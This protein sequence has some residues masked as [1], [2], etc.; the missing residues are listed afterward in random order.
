[1]TLNSGTSFTG[2]GNVGLSGGQL[3]VGS[4]ISMDIGLT[5]SM[6]SGTMSGTGNLI[7][8]G[9]FNW[10]GG[11]LTSAGSTTCNGALTVSGTAALSLGQRILNVNAATTYTGTG[12]LTLSNGA[13]INNNGTWD[14]QSDVTIA[15]GSGAGS[16]FKNFGTFRKSAGAGTTTVQPP[17]TNS[18]TVDVQSGT[19]S[20]ASYSQTAGTTK[21]TGGAFTSAAN[22]A[23]SGGSLAGSGSV[24][25][26][27][28]VSGT[29]ALAPG[30][31][32]GTLS[33]GGAYTQQAPSGAFNVEL[34]GLTPGTQYDRV[35]VMGAAALAGVLN[36]SLI[37]G[38]APA[39]G[40][41]F[42]IMTY[43]SRTGTF[44]VSLPAAPCVDWQVTYGATA[45]VLTA[46][47]A[48]PPVEIAQLTATNAT[49]LAWTAGSAAGIV[50]DVM[51]GDLG[52]LPVGPG[53]GETCLAT[54]IATATTSDSTP[55]APGAGFW[56][57]VR[58]RVAGC[59][60]GTYGFAT[61]GVERISTACP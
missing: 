26:P 14:A 44:T 38:F 35:D 23:I 58:G 33:L 39:P 2:T 12:T 59:G 61:D 25:G 55:L 19:L 53:A 37:G 47:A 31:S 13:T 18:G 7:L 32:A 1:M 27:V 15:A 10:S 45:L 48:A 3:I 9:P 41:S 40:D 28:V 57:V 60:T 21:L 46:L 29:G 4:Q 50:Y 52:T 17:F 36:V 6:S 49:T 20:A 51:R 43:A 11:L 5:F 42:T 24:S 8:L 16:S 54:G 22:I 56:Y 34:G 30:L